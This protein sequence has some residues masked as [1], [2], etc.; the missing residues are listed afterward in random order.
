MPREAEPLNRN[1]V[2][3][4]RA[5]AADPD[6]AH[7][8]TTV[9]KYEDV[10]GRDTDPVR[11]YREMAAPVVDKK[12]RRHRRPLGTLLPIRAA[13]LAFLRAEGFSEEEIEQ[14][15]L[16]SARGQG[17]QARRALSAEELADYLRAVRKIAHPVVPWVLAF[18]PRTGLRISEVVALGPDDV[19]AR[20]SG[21]ALKVIGKGA[22]IRY[23]PLVPSALNLLA[24]IQ[25]E[26]S[27]Y[28]PNR[29]F[30]RPILA[31]TVQQWAKQLTMTDPRFR[32]VTPHSLR[33]TFATLGLARGLS[34]PDVQRVL[35]HANA[36]TTM[37]YLQ[38]T[39]ADVAKRVIDAWEDLP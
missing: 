39:E 28:F 37:R 8:P 19:V 31:R 2:R 32:A 10:L 14:L 16:P 24:Q 3:Y 6:H 7:G 12:G 21:S 26:G 4:R 29:T 20:P 36:Q 33:A 27:W 9:A 38:P 17:A 30:T 22:K 13:T 1:Q 18:L 15:Q 25:P 11:Y 34:I 5:A 23:V 35:G